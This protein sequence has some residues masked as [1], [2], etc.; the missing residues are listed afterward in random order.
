MEVGVYND[1]H[2]QSRP[3]VDLI[4]QILDLLLIWIVSMF[5]MFIIISITF[6]DWCINFLFIAKFKSRFPLKPTYHNRPV[7]YTFVY[8]DGELYGPPPF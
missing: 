4:A 6:Y 8:T 1:V 7:A 5:Y 3:Y 2:L